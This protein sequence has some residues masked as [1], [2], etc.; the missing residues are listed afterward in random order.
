M[1]IKEKVSQ[2]SRTL[3]YAKYYCDE[4]TPCLVT[5][6]DAIQIATEQDSI[7]RQEE[8]ERCIKI[9]Q[10]KMCSICKTAHNSCG[11]GVIC[12]YGECDE[13][14]KLRKEME[15]GDKE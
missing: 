5:K 15:K 2:V 10:D 14:E 8:R 7:A 9:A 13:R 6:N 11:Y 12:T 1:T 4:K 3:E